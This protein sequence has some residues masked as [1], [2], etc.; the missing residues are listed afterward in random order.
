MYI[1]MLILGRVKSSLL[2]RITLFW[3]CYQ[4]KIVRKWLFIFIERESDIEFIEL[5]L[6]KLEYKGILAGA[7]CTITP[8]SIAP[9]TPFGEMLFI[10]S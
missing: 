8:Q 2:W 9:K 7:F 3:E 4:T 5:W 6:M 10:S 1:H